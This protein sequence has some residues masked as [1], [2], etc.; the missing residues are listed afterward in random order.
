MDDLITNGTATLHNYLAPTAVRGRYVAADPEDNPDDE[1]WESSCQ[2]DKGANYT[3]FAETGNRSKNYVK[4]F[5]PPE[6]TVRPESHYGADA[7]TRFE[8]TKFPDVTFRVL[9]VEL[10]DVDD[11][12]HILARAVREDEAPR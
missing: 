10:W 8:H 11:P 2:P 4:L 1:E 3:A 12:A 9:S 6:A 5:L 7:A